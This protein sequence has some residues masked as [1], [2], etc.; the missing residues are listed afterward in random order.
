[1]SNDISLA[2]ITDDY[3]DQQMHQVELTDA[4]NGLPV[5]TDKIT[6]RNNTKN[7][8]TPADSIRSVQNTTVIQRTATN[9]TKIKLN[10]NWSDLAWTIYAMSIEVIRICVSSLLVVFVSQNCTGHTCTFE[11]NFVELI[12]INKAALGWNFIT[13]ILMLVFYAINYHREKYLIYT[14]DEDVSIPNTNITEVFRTHPDVARRITQLNR[15]LKYATGIAIIT[16]LINIALSITVILGYY[17]NGYQSVFQLFIQASLCLGVLYRSM[18]NAMA[19][20]EDGLVQSNIINKPQYF[21]VIDPHY[22]AKKIEK[23]TDNS[24]HI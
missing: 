12:A 6:N 3:V 22:Y 14:L 1:M 15:V 4:N 9:L 24:N 7:Q 11:E 21:N 5:Y 13:L 8:Q 19:T 18:D 17:Y 23:T 10:N 2:E 16:Y 20:E